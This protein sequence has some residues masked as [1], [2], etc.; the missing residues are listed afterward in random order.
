MLQKYHLIYLIFVRYMKHNA[1]NTITCIIWSDD[2]LCE[3]YATKTSS[4][5]LYL[6]N[7]AR[8]GH[9]YYGTL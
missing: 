4:F 2:K 1:D 8:Y 9:S 5:S 7:G 3:V 6:R